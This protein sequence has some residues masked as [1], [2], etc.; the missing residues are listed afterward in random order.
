MIWLVGPKLHWDR[1]GCVISPCWMKI[2]SAIKVG[3]E[4]R[5]MHPNYHILD[6]CKII[7]VEIYTHPSN[8]NDFFG[9]GICALENS[10]QP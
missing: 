1:S 4:G 2:L 8:G 3:I 5:P 6:H 9:P 7:L 10:M